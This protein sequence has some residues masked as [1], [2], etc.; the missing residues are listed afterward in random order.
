MYNAHV[1]GLKVNGKPKKNEKTR[2]SER[3]SRDD[4]DYWRLL[5]G[6]GKL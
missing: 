2:K 6:Y 5:E 3:N 1:H 4:E